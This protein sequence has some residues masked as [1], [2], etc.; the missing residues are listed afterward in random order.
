MQVVD[1]LVSGNRQDAPGN[2]AVQVCAYAVLR[3][4][5]ALQLRHGHTQFASNTG[6]VVAQLDAVVAAAVAGV[7][8]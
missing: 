7:R 5:I 8:G 3:V 1:E 4:Q 6:H 2:D